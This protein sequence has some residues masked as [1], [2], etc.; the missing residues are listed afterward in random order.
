MPFSNTAELIGEDT[1]T[2]SVE[3]RHIATV[4]SS[5]I[6]GDAN[7]IKI[8]K[9]AEESLSTPL[10]G[11]KFELSTVAMENKSPKIGANGPALEQ[12]KVGTTKENGEISFT[13]MSLVKADSTTYTLYCLKET[14]A[15]EGR[16]I[17]QEYREGYYFILY[18]DGGLSKAEEFQKQASAAIEKEVHLIIGGNTLTISNAKVKTSSVKV[19]KLFSGLDS[20]PDGFQI[21]NSYN[22][23]V[24]TAKNAEKGTG[25]TGDPYE[26]TIENVPVGTEI[27]F[28]ESGYTKDGYSVTINGKAVTEE[29]AD[30]VAAT[31]KESEIK[32]AAFTNVYRSEETSTSITKIWDD[33][34]NRDNKRP[35]SIDVKLTA[36]VGGSE[37]TGLSK[38][39]TLKAA[40]GWKASWSDLPKYY[41][42][43]LVEYSAD[44]VNTPAGYTKSVSG[45]ITK[46][47]TITN[48][49]TP[50]TIQVS[51]SKNWN[52][53]GNAAG[54]RPGSI[55]IRLYANGS[56]IDHKTVT[57]KDGWSWNW[58]G[59]NRYDTDHKEISY[60]ISEDAVD[61]YTSS[62]S[63]Y[64]VTNTVNKPQ[65]GSVIL[66][67]VDATTGTALAG[68]IFD[69]YRA[70]NTKVG[71]YTTNAGG[72]LR[73]DG[74]T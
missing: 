20:L 51:G 38:T 11:A 32:T 21:T 10:P 2:D 57:E 47:F 9:V 28:T 33:D 22:D 6:R 34:N 13:E 16:T 56:E 30:K 3:K 67:K 37:I 71:T 8:K 73:V 69:L 48:R 70:N 60:T 39:A 23:T 18:A 42:G 1:F 59:L 40:N 49:Y 24:F 61:G 4:N 12:P 55:T 36:K 66:T 53:D 5:W 54:T 31:S 52:D 25:K 46:G 29:N 7:T 26:W 17:S 63:G 58:T 43:Q 44:E 68:A 72:V 64:N 74:L 27:T 15:P 14:N 62:I 45:D 19:T 65:V 41:N 50:E 35:A